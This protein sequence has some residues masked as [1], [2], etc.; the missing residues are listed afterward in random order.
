MAAGN[1]VWD[2]IREQNRKMKGKPFKEKFAYFWE[3]Y[4]NMTIV[5]ILV[6]IFGGNLIYSVA[7]ATDN[8]LGV[9]MIN[10]YT[11]MDPYK[12]MDDY[13]LFAEINTKKFHT[14][15]DVNFTVDPDSFDEF[16]IA[17]IQKLS[18]MVAASQIDVLFGAENSILGYAQTGFFLDVREVLPEKIYQ[19]YEDGMIWYDIP[20]DEVDGEVPVAL[21]VNDT[22]LMQE[23]G[24]YYGQDAY[25]AFIANSVNPENA[26]KFLEYIETAPVPMTEQTAW[27]E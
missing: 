7:T 18:A 5:I 26:V 11:S 4:R 23:S 27:G 19:K 13:N 15:L 17:N 6:L 16:S 9:I 20:D 24:A 1:S 21:K 14:N 25:L 3:Y 2:E 12:Y 10:S 8:A 22:A